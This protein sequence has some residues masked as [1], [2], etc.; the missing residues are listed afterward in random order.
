MG[1]LEFVENKARIII[2]VMV[3]SKAAD[4]CGSVSRTALRISRDVRRAAAV[5]A[6][7]GTMLWYD[8]DCTFDAHG[9][10]FAK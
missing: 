8:L 4:A 9:E 2:R 3:S 6:D 5:T 1:G 10:G 7:R